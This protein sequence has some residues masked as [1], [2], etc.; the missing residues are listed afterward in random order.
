MPLRRQ[1]AP[2]RNLQCHRRVIQETGSRT[3][4]K[5]KE[6]ALLDTV[7]GIPNAELGEPEKDS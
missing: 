5:A 2:F 7:G 3:S 4:A 6:E 1:A